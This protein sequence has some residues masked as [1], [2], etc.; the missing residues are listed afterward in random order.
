ML[1]AG[2]ARINR[3]AVNIRKRHAFRAERHRTAAHARPC[4]GRKLTSPPPARAAAMSADDHAPDAA[5]PLGAAAD[6]EPTVADQIRDLV[7]LLPKEKLI[8]LLVELCVA[9]RRRLRARR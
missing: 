8:E 9:A 1:G 7:D 5:M 4:G 2:A 6:E 3:R